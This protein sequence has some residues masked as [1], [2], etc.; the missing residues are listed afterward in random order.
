[1]YGNLFLSTSTK[2]ISG[3]KKKDFKKFYIPLGNERTSAKLLHGRGELID[4]RFE[5]IHFP[6][7]F[8]VRKCKFRKKNQDISIYM[9]TVMLIVQHDTQGHLES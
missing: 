1:V 8:D 6:C 7:T 4:L 2:S 5:E 3:L 9:G